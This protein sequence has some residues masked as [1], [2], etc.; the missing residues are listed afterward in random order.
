M[1]ITLLGPR[2]V[3]ML[4]EMV[5]DDVPS[6]EIPEG[7]ILANALIQPLGVALRYLYTMLEAAHLGSFRE[8]DRLFL[9]LAFRKN[10]ADSGLRGPSVRQMQKA[11]RVISQLTS[12]GR[13]LDG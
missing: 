8:Y 7:G 1:K 10:P 11:W 2:K 3:P 12:T 5:H 13:S 6:R 4:E 9:K